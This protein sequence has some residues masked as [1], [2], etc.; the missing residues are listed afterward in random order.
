M[1]NSFA[2]QSFITPVWLYNDDNDDDDADENDYT[3]SRV[4]YLKPPEGIIYSPWLWRPFSSY[5]TYFAI[6]KIA[7]L[8]S[9]S[10]QPYLVFN[11]IKTIDKTTLLLILWLLLLWRFRRITN[12]NIFSATCVNAPFSQKTINTHF[13]QK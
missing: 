8:A 12:N 4:N 1:L 3:R 9:S 7:P 5:N 11:N 6:V 10:P 13:Y 2:R